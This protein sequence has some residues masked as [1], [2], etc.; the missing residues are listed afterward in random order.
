MQDVARFSMEN[1]RKVAS[2]LL[3]YL[4]P[5]A[6]FRNPTRAIREDGYARLRPAPTPP[7]VQDVV[8]FL[9]SEPVYN[10][11]VPVYSDGI[12]RPLTPEYDQAFGSYDLEQVVR[13]PSTGGGTEPVP[14]APGG[15]VPRLPADPLLVARLVVV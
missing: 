2:R 9:K 11:H 7:Q 10:G 4:K 15:G 1:R 13:C 6:P 8:T 3:R 5:R 12:R 14:F